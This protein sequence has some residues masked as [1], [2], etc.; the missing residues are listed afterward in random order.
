MSPLTLTADQAAELAGYLHHDGTGNGA[1]VRALY[2]A[3]RF[4]APIDPDL[5]VRSW[6]WS[7]RD[8]ERYVEHGV[9]A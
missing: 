5:K 8:V 4:P 9:A 1:V 6:R 7:R 2:R 3:G